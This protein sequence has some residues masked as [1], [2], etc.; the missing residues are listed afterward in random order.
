[1]VNGGCGQSK[2]MTVGCSA[3]LTRK[4]GIAKIASSL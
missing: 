4:T 2:T 3:D 1:V